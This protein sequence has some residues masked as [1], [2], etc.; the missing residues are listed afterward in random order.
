MRDKRDQHS[1]NVRYFAA[2]RDRERERILTRQRARLELLRGLKARPCADCA[3]TYLPHQMDFDHRDP[4]KKSFDLADG[5]TLLRS[6]ASVL[7]EVA[8]CD[9]VCANCHRTRTRI[10]HQRR[11]AARGPSAAKSRYIERK[12][13]R[14]RTDASLLDAIR[15]VPCMDCGERLPPWAM[16]FDHRDPATKTG[17]VTQMIGRAS[18]NRLL[19]EV[20][21]CDIVCTNCHRDR[22]F[23]RRTAAATP[24]RE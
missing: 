16:E 20:D 11:L 22:T 15:N 3:M 18:L 19:A 12:R 14:W 7:A 9:V 24:E 2:H 8:K 6:E 5:T 1:F 13:A 10:W 4:S 21:R 23:R 17:T